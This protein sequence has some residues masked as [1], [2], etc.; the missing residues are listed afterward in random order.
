MSSDLSRD[1]SEAKIAVSHRRDLIF[2]FQSQLSVAHVRL[3]FVVVEE[4]TRFRRLAR[5]FGRY[6]RTERGSALSSPL[7]KLR[8]SAELGMFAPAIRVFVVGRRA[9]KRHVQLGLSKLERMRDKYDQWRGGARPGA[10]RPSFQKL[11]LRK[12]ASERHQKR[13][14][15]R[16]SW[17]AHVILRAHPDIGSLRKSDVFHAIR[18]GWH[19]RGVEGARVSRWPALR[20][21]ALLHHAARVRAPNLVVGRRLAQA[22][23]DQR[24]R[25]AQ[26]Q[27]RVNATARLA[28]H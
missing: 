7:A 8:L 23:A 17:P 3:F 18:E 12:R 20:A 25:S 24:V 14:A 11:G 10:G 4:R 16:A 26:S 9:R 19:V 6:R 27:R 28:L 1:I 15:L 13:L 2:L 21:A 22:R 5:F